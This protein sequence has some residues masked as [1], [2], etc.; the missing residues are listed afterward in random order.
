MRAAWHLY[1]KTFP[2]GEDKVPGSAKERIYGTVD[3][4]SYIGKVAG[5]MAGSDGMRRDNYDV[6]KRW[7]ERIMDVRANGESSEC[8][9]TA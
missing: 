3:A 7:K 8:G 6:L 5:C 9:S 2:D 4:S 1:D